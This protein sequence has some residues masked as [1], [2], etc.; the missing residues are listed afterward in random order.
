[1]N[2]WSGLAP[3]TGLV[4]LLVGLPSQ[5]AAVSCGVLQI[6]LTGD[7]RATQNVA[8]NLTGLVASEV[9]S[10]GAC[11]DVVKLQPPAGQVGCA[12]DDVCVSQLAA[13]HNL[14]LVVSGEVRYTG[15]KVLI[16]LQ[17]FDSN[18]GFFVEILQ[19]RVSAEPTVLPDHIATFTVDLL[20]AHQPAPSAAAVPGPEPITPPPIVPISPTPAPQPA[21]TPA[22]PA[23][24]V[25]VELQTPTGDAPS[26]APAP[27]EPTAPEVL[28]DESTD[29]GEL[30]LE[31][32]E[33]ATLGAVTKQHISFKTTTGYA[34]YQEPQLSLG[35]TVD[36]NLKGNK[37]IDIGLE[38][39]TG[40]KRKVDSD[41]RW[42][43]VILPLGI[44]FGVKGNKRELVHPY[45]TI[46]GTAILCYTDPETG[47]P[48]F[49]PGLR[50]DAGVDLLFQ[51]HF[52]MFLG[53]TAGVVYGGSAIQSLVDDSY[54]PIG[55]MGSLRTGLVIQL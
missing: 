21:A 6:H 3:V 10:T 20:G 27:V 32:R 37:I 42:T 12:T 26:P 9:Q 19:R 47:S 40:A 38:S 18:E 51:P 29:L 5:A 7:E 11:T 15:D 13:D 4:G 14:S 54:A 50:A 24:Y 41:E 33:R 55:F 22:P 31:R 46:G 2:P 8:A 48:A 23:G 44:G 53:S 28:E 16:K 45:A 36:I 43:Y 39:W 17:L 30:D 34:N 35:L 52:G 49:I 1:M 25:R